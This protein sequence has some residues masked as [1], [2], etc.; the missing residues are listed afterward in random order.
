MWL[1][2]QLESSSRV[3]TRHGC[4]FVY[5]GETARNRYAKSCINPE[6][7]HPSYHQFKMCFTQCHDKTLGRLVTEAVKISQSTQP[8]LNRKRGYRVNNVLSVTSPPADLSRTNTRQTV[9]PETCR[10]VRTLYF[11]PFQ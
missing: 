11:S 8:V 5:Y 7:F 1:Q 9:V 6:F 10:K 2:S 4:E 3:C